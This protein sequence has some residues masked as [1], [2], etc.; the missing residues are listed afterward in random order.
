MKLPSLTFL[1]LGLC[2]LLSFAA[3]AA[4]AVLHKDPVTQQ[5]YFMHES[6]WNSD[7]EGR[8]DIGWTVPVFM[9]DEIDFEK[10]AAGDLLYIES[11]ENKLDQ[12]AVNVVVD[13]K[14]DKI[15]TELYEL[16]QALSACIWY[17]DR[18]CNHTE[19]YAK[20]SEKD[21]LVTLIGNGKWST[22]YFSLAL[23][24]EDQTGISIRAKT[25]NLMPI[26]ENDLTIALD[27]SQNNNQAYRRDRDKLVVWTDENVKI[28]L[29]ETNSLG[30]TSVKFTLSLNSSV[31]KGMEDDSFVSDNTLSYLVNARTG[32]ETLAVEQIK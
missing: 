9:A 16:N 20:Y 14:T 32:Y 22:R 30:T 10:I 6:E 2:S 31:P 5:K 21:K 19:I 12:W 28:I 7:H 24:N 3:L 18:G 27:K 17:L 1:S 4:P 25:S 26:V 23:I 13:T 11:I 29:N 15:V 8:L